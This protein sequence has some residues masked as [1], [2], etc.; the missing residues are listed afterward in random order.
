MALRPELLRAWMKWRKLD[1][2]VAAARAGAQRSAT[3]RIEIEIDHLQSDVCAL[4]QA[5]LDGKNWNYPIRAEER[6]TDAIRIR[7]ATNQADLRPE[8]RDAL[9][10]YLDATEAVIKQIAL[11]APRLRLR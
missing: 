7:E 1:A 10:D 11:E 9:L 6:L 5:L 8:H 3:Y 4:G 2:P